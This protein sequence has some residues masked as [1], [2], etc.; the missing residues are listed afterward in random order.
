MI[1]LTDFW[2]EIPFNTQEESDTDST[3]KTPPLPRISTSSQQHNFSCN[4]RVIIPCG[5]GARKQDS[6]RRHMYP[7]TQSFLNSYQA[8][9]HIAKS[10]TGSIA[11]DDR[12]ECI[13]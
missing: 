1:C 4:E 6:V 13:L 8:P 7:P 12:S 3:K 11:T 9:V 2:S 5:G 10:L